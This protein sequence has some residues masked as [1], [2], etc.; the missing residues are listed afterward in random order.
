VWLSFLG[1]ELKKLYGEEAF[2]VYQ[3]APLR[4]VDVEKAA[5]QGHLE[6]C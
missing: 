2:G 1:D 6:N 5:T 4:R 3:L